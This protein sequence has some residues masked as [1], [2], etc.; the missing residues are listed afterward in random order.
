MASSLVSTKV[1]KDRWRKRIGTHWDI[2]DVGEWF[3]SVTIPKLFQV[4]EL[5]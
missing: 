3:V 5:L 2:W 4:G 1:A